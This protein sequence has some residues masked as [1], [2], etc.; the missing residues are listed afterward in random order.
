MEQ[1][2]ELVK[3][4]EVESLSGEQVIIDLIGYYTD[5][6]P[7]GEHD[8]FDLFIEDD[9]DCLNEGD[10]LYSIPTQKQ[11]EKI[12]DEFMGLDEPENIETTTKEKVK[13]SKPT[14]E[15]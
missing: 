4:Y 3:S 6:T 15:D 2:E 12:Y 8:F 1:Q 13:R 10:P 7:E 11:V 5:N 14:K 9:G